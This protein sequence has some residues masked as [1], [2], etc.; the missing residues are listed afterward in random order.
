MKRQLLLIPLLMAIAAVSCFLTYSVLGQI[1]TK[2][3]GAPRC[4]AFND[5][6]GSHCYQLKC[7]SSDSFSNYQGVRRYGRH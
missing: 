4:V 5:A 7:V 6:Q 2:T 1:V 3:L